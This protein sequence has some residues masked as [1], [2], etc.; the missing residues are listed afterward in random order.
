MPELSA[1]PEN[2]ADL[3]QRHHEE[4]KNYLSVHYYF[5]PEGKNHNS[6]REWKRTTTRSI[7]RHCGKISLSY[8][9]V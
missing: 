6:K 5:H 4:T 8:Y 1:N 2:D 7:L 9:N 3:H